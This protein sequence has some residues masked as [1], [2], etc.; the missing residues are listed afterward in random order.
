MKTGLKQAYNELPSWAKGVIFVGGALALVAVVIS[1]KNYIKK[2]KASKDLKT[3]SN[4]EKSL[5]RKY[6]P[7]YTDAQNVAFANQIYESV[8]YGV[9]D[10]YSKVVEVMKKMKNDLDVA[11]L[12]RAYGSRQRY[13][14]G[15]PVGEPM[16][17]FT[18]MAAELGNE[19]GGLTSYRIGQI[20]SDWKSKGITYV[21]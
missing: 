6:T 21:L 5:E 3:W 12:V 10:D 20:N 13:N 2:V 18:T 11:R 16:D 19:Y 14:F 4:E 8:R 7:T 9:G 17:L 15:I 1:V